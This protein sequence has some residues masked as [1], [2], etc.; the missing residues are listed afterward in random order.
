MAKL[1][2]CFHSWF[3]PPSLLVLRKIWNSIYSRALSFSHIL[4]WNSLNAIVYCS[5]T[6]AGAWVRYLHDT[7]CICS[8][9]RWCTFLYTSPNLNCNA[10]HPTRNCCIFF[11]QNLPKWHNLLSAW[12]FLYDVSILPACCCAYNWHAFPFCLLFCF[13]EFYKPEVLYSS[14]GGKN[15]N[16]ILLWFYWVWSFTIL[17]LFLVAILNFTNLRCCTVVEEG[18]GKL[19]VP[20]QLVQDVA[21]YVGLNKDGQRWTQMNT[22]KQR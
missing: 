13:F 11:W 4:L 17:L 9:S 1:M 3:Y 20:A 14:G 8:C 5:K 2:Y 18:R 12:H 19:E 16:N 10:V 6:R 22:D 15:G 21:H 7:F